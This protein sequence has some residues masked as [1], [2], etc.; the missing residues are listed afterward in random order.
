MLKY[1]PGP[2]GGYEWLYV[3]EY[4]WTQVAIAALLQYVG[5]CCDCLKYLDTG[6]VTYT[7]RGEDD[8]LE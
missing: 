2:N 5:Q 7:L 1:C 6:N 3:F 8:E 4:F